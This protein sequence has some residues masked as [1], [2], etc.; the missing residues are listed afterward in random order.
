MP[1]SWQA[2]ITRTAISPRFATRTRRI[3]APARTAAGR[4]RPPS[5][6]STR[7][8]GDHA[9][10][11]R[12]QLV[13]QLHRLEQAERLADLDAVADADERRLARRRRAVEVADDRALDDDAGVGAAAAAPP[14][15]RPAVRGHRDGHERLVLLL[16]HRDARAAV[17]DRQ[18]AGAGVLEDL[19]QPAHA[20]GL[21]GVGGCGRWRRSGSRGRGRARSARSA[22]SPNSATRHSSSS[23]RRRCRRPGPARRRGRAPRSRRAPVPAARRRAMASSEMVPGVWPHSPSSELAHL[24]G[25]RRPAPAGRARGRWPGAGSAADGRGGR[26]RAELGPHDVE[27]LQH[28]VAAGRTRRGARAGA[29]GWR[30]ARVDAVQ[31]GEQRD[32]RRDAAARSSRRAECSVDRAR[33]LPRR[34]SRSSPGSSADAARAPARTARRW[35]GGVR[36]ATG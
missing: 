17:L 1:S 33:D 25:H 3:T 11:L 26:R 34:G 27:L 22:S 4:T 10:V 23:E 32:V 20:L 31:R 8:L 28:L 35:P 36:M 18:L 2:R 14:S 12:L 29:R 30:Q 15:W 5:A 13:E 24:L 19:D 16:A 21:A 6:S 9:G 7:I